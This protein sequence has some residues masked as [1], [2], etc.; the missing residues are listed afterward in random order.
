MA[1]HPSATSTHRLAALALSGVLTTAGASGYIE[2]LLLFLV[3]LDPWRGPSRL[4]VL[5]SAYLLCVSFDLILFPLPMLPTHSWLGG[6]AVTPNAGVSLGQLV[7]PGLVLIIQYGL[8]ADTLA[9]VV[10]I[11][12]SV[13]PLLPAP[14][15]GA[16]GGVRGGS[17]LAGEATID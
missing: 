10:R 13:T 12:A 14:L 5:A 7:R 16:M 8:V 17:P 6:R 2:V 11:K 3:F 1:R 4:P 9:E 15:K